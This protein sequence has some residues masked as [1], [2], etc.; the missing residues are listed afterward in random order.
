MEQTQSSSQVSPSLPQQV[1]A[2]PVFNKPASKLN[3]KILTLII[4]GLLVLGGGTYYFFQKMEKPVEPIIFTK[5]EYE[6]FLKQI[7]ET[8]NP[9]FS[10]KEIKS[11]EEQ[12]SKTSNPTFSEEEIA[13]FME[14][15]AKS[16][17][18]IIQ[19]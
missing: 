14:Q 16:R 5:E 6:A 12:V 19:Q 8:P 15:I 3:S 4:G 17:P 7:N 9:K 18:V 2:T 1:G 10:N 11:F 13:N